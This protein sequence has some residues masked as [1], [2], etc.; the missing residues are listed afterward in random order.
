MTGTLFRAAMSR[1]RATASR[2]LA[3]SRVCRLEG[4]SDNRA[5]DSPLG[6]RRPVPR[7]QSWAIDQ[8]SGRSLRLTS[9]LRSSDSPNVFS[10]VAG[11]HSGG[12]KRAAEE[13]VFWVES[14]AQEAAEMNFGQTRVEHRRRVKNDVRLESRARRR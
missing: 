4:R 9:S 12:E 5:V 14:I 2:G 3:A 11:R 10:Q 8:R 13:V 7:A 6:N 1:W